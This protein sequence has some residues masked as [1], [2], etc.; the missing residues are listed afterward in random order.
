MNQCKNY[1]LPCP[2]ALCTWSELPCI[3]TQENCDI[4]LEK[5]KKEAPEEFK[6]AVELRKKQGLDEL[7]K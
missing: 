3:G 7:I 2:Y 1:L 5:Y 4:W 6:K